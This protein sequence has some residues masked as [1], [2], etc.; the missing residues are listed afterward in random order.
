MPKVK[1]ELKLLRFSKNKNVFDGF[2]VRDKR[3]SFIN[4]KDKSVVRYRLSKTATQSDYIAG[5]H[6]IPILEEGNLRPSDGFVFCFAGH[7]TKYKDVM[8]LTW[9]RITQQFALAFEM[10]GAD[11]AR[12]EETNLKKAL[13]HYYCGISSG[14]SL[15][16][17]MERA[18][19]KAFGLEWHAKLIAEDWA[20]DELALLFYMLKRQG[21]IK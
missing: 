3:V 6:I 16:Y 14:R 4:L 15:G 11:I 2:C 10:I 20:D 7:H 19:P 9:V 17:V 18:L 1:E 13:A 21:D 12:I 8:R 5:R